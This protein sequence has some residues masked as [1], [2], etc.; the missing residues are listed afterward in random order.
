[1]KAAG[2]FSTKPGVEHAKDF[3]PVLAGA[4]FENLMQTRPGTNMLTAP[5]GSII[6][7]WPVESQ[8]YTPPGQSQKEISGHIDI[9][10]EVAGKT[11]WL[12]DFLAH[13]PAYGVSAR[14]LVSGKSQKYHVSFK[15]IG[16]WY[17]A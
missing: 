14:T 4:G 12:S 1:M 5:I 15:I 16:I 7:Y 3:G 10:C 8:R 6:I 11:R 9:K 2:Y 17:K 13:N